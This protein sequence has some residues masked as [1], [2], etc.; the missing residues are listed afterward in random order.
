MGY[1]MGIGRGGDGMGIGVRKRDGGLDF[2]WDGRVAWEM[3]SGMGMGSVCTEL[4]VLHTAIGTQDTAR[5]GRYQWVS[6]T[7]Y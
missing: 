1:G 6:R 2:K 5:G 7:I 4:P 3:E